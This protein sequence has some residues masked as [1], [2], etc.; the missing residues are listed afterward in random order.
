MTTWTENDAI[1]VELL[2]AAPAPPANAAAVWTL[3]LS[4]AMGA[5]LEGA[6]LLGIPY[7]ED[8]GH[9]RATPVGEEIEPG[10]YELGPLGL[11]MPGLWLVTLRIAPAGGEQT[12]AGFAFCIDD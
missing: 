2:S 12:D 10:V 11:T 9:V 1:E 7:M 8:H 4:D 3:A 5:P 6:S